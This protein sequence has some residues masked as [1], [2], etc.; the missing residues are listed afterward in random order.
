[1]SQS[2]D[3]K[4]VDLER[5]YQTIKEEIDAAI[6][7]VISRTNFILGD[8]VHLFEKEFA[9]YCE[10]A[11]AVGVDNGTSALEMA[12]RAL[13]IG[14]GDDVLVPANSFMA[15]ASAV[16]F[17]GAKPVFVDVDPVT[18]LIDVTQLARRITPRTRAIIP[19]HLYGQAADM[20]PIMEFAREHNLL[21]VEDACQA[22]GARYKGR[23]VGGIGHAAAFSFYPGKNLGA[24]GDGGA[25]VT[26]DAAVA[27]ALRVMRNCGQREKYT[28]VMLS[29]NRRLDTLQ[30]AILRVKLRYLDQWNALRRQWAVLLNELLADSGAVLPVTRPE[31]EHVFHLYVVQV[32]ERSAVQE[33]LKQRNIATG[34][35]YPL[36]IHLQPAYAELGYKQGDFPVTEAAAKRILS[37]PMFAEL[38]ESEVRYIAEMFKAAIAVGRAEPLMQSVGA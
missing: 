33:F 4:F 19:V 5:Q 16:S 1:M 28:H 29:Y 37:L 38:T 8:H 3:I 18:H 15:S 32:E 35:H 23:R 14:P 36:P 2:F 25:V 22:H 17:V 6:A 11:E 27:E 34:I 20:D 12:L 9:A 13:G 26:N 31:N 30:A 10:A 7:D 21:V 24:Y